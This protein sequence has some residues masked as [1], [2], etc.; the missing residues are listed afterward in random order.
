MI[1]PFRLGAILLL[2]ASLHAE[3]Q[4][5]ADDDLPAPFDAGVADQLL[6]H[7][8]FNRI[9]NPED[10]LQLTGIAYVEGKPVATFLNKETKER[11]TVSEVPNPQGWKI[12]EA[13]PGNDP[14][15]T[16]VHVMIGGE[17][18]TMHY[19]DS[20]LT[21]GATKKGAPGVYIA[22]SGSPGG[23]GSS[24]HIKTSSLL[25]ENGKQL[26]VSL[27]HEARDKLKEIVHD[28]MDKHPEQSMEQ[29]SAYAQKMYAKIKA[30]DTKSTGN[31]SSVKS[32]N[33]SNNIKT[34]KPSRNR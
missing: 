12:T 10:T 13:I 23:S 31:T 30:T 28:H 17:D 15:T 34:G 7:S 29:N 20:Q 16:E 33:K 4:P 25:G 14:Q 32:T 19:G 26:Y 5:V 2:A 27:S 24:D 6:T 11:V 8:P 1:T 3:D 9:V 22:R 21:P 18:I